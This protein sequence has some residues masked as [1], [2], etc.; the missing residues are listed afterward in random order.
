[1]SMRI[2]STDPRLKQALAEWAKIA[3]GLGLVA[4][5]FKSKVIWQK[6][7]SNRSHIVVRLKGPRVLI[8]KRTF[9]AQ[10]SD[11]L[12]EKVITQRDAFQ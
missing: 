2:S 4:S 11:D 12:V 1:M 6:D 7:E 8:L 5:D 3:P 9:V 10:D